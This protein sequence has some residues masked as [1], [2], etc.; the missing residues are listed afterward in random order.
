[1]KLQFEVF[2]I[3]N[4][5]V[6]FFVLMII[7]LIVPI[8]IFTIMILKINANEIL[9][10]I[11]EFNNLKSYAITSIVLFIINILFLIALHY[12]T[13]Q[14]SAFF[15]H[16]YTFFNLVFMCFGCYYAINKRD[17]MFK[18]MAS[19][20]NENKVNIDD[21]KK[22]YNCDFYGNESI[23][24]VTKEV[25]STSVDCKPIVENKITELAK[26]CTTLFA[27]TIVFVIFVLAYGFWIGCCV[28]KSEDE[29]ERDPIKDQINP[30]DSFSSSD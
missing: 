25:T 30:D 15:M 28:Y 2:G 10:Q 23:A 19:N 7:L 5:P 11:S 3:K 27:I 21:V 9:L 18:T 1:M 24:N 6:I 17:D 12:C 14:Y 8:V 22:K 16:F 26:Q 20:I 29:E 13:Q 4:A